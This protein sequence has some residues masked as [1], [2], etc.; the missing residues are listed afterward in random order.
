MPNLNPVVVNINAGGS[1]LLQTGPED[2]NGAPAVP[3]HNFSWAVDDATL[4]AITTSGAGAQTGT[5][6]STGKAG[7]AH[8]TA[9]DTFDGPGGGQ[10]VIVN[11]TVN[12]GGF[13]T[14]CVPSASVIS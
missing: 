14:Q 1:A 11:F 3:E 8:I 4:G 12:I 5:F 13:F 7:T 6:V 10:T 9:T 2:S